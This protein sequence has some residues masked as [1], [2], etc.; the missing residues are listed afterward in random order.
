MKFKT[1]RVAPKFDGDITFKYGSSSTGYGM[2]GTSKF[3]DNNEYKYKLG[4][5]FYPEIIIEA[6]SEEGERYLL[7][8][9]G[10][11]F[12]FYTGICGSNFRLKYGEEHRFKLRLIDFSGNK[13]EEIKHIKFKV[14]DRI[15]ELNYPDKD[16]I[17]EGIAVDLPNNAL[18]MSSIHKKKITAT[19]IRSGWTEDLIKSEE[20][21]YK[22]GVGL[23]IKDHKL[24]ALSREEKNGKIISD[25]LVIDFKNIKN[26]N[27]YKFSDTVSHFMN[28]L[29]I[30]DDNKIYITD[31]KRHCVYKLN[32]PEGEIELFIEDEQIKYPNGITISE[33]NK[34]LYV[35][36]WSHG[37]RIIDISTK[38]ILNEKNNLTSEIGIDGM[39]Y[40]QGNLY[41]IRN[42]GNDRTKHGLIKI[43]LS[44]EGD[45]ITGVEPLL[46]NDPMMN[47]PTTIDIADGTIYILANSQIGNLNQETNEIKNKD[48]LTNTYILKYRIKAEN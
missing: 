27:K 7:T 8:T 3:W 31:T 34:K 25:L 46:M 35:D 22:S 11:S 18:Y 33:D 36:S 13:S 12:G 41:A 20:H 2:E 48:K 28:D 39:K 4:A 9:L 10:N 47:I 40:Y 37:V 16:L 44:D 6:I 24:F 43:K 38:K 21:G 32:Y 14:V 29:A 30:S 1:D 17:P 42:G 45:D 26:V 5:K 19:Y 15:I 23:E